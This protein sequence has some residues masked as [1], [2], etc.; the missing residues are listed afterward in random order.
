M[1]K[2]RSLGSALAVIL[3]VALGD[4]IVRAEGEADFLAGKT[5]FCAGCALEKA[6]ITRRDL[7]GVDLSGAKL[8]GAVMPCQWLTAANFG[9]GAAPML[10]EPTS[11]GPT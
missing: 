11:P 6:Q 9:G 4:T 10:P 8:M 1:S 5:K 7:A 2:S 3:A